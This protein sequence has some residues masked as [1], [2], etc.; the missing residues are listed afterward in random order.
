MFMRA[1]VRE[2]PFHQDCFDAAL[3]RSCFH[4]LPPETGYGT[5]NAA[6]SCG[7]CQAAAAGEPPNGWRA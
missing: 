3:D 2:L 4:Y 6:A 5:P 7:P 1:D